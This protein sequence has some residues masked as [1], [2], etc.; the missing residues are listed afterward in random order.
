MSENVPYVRGALNED[1][2]QSGPHLSGA[3]LKADPGAG[4]A[5][6]ATFRA[7]PGA[8]GEYQT[9]DISKGP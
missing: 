4:L 6:H 5:T 7:P 3:S 2:P 8:A 1:G 9:T